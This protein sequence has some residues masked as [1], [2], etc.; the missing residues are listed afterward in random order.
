MRDKKGDIIMRENNK[1]WMERNSKELTVA[2]TDEFV[3]NEIVDA[4]EIAEV[5]GKVMFLEPDGT[6]V[7]KPK[8]AIVTN[9]ER[10]NIRSSASKD[11]TVLFIIPVGTILDVDFYENDWA[12]VR[13]SDDKEGY[14]MKAFIKEVN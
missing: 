9:C 10:L 14:V 13:T 1:K 12:H 5:P 2:E 11:A 3:N 4:T 8:Q 6:P 7:V